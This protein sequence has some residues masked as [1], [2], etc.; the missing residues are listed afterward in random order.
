MKLFVLYFDI[1]S[2]FGEEAS[3]GNLLSFWTGSDVIPPGGLNNLEVRYLGESCLL[4]QAN[5][6]FGILKIPTVQST[7]EQF[8]KSMNTGILYG[9]GHFGQL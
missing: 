5:A 3:L 6:C 7:K 9:N 4:P 1:G 2:N 8:F